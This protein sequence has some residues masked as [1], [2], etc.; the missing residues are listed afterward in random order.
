MACARPDGRLRL[1]RRLILL[2]HAILNTP[3]LGIFL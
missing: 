3:N 2:D 1:A